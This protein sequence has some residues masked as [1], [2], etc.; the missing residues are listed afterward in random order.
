MSDARR[1]GSSSARATAASAT[2]V[3][4]RTSGQ[5]AHLLRALLALCFL[6][7]AA[8]AQAQTYQWRDVVQEVE[9]RP[10]GDVFV[11]DTRTLW[12]NEDF[13]EAFLCLDLRPPAL[14]PDLRI[15]VTYLDTSGALGSGPTWR[16][17]RQ[18]CDLAGGGRG[19]ELVVRNDRRSPNAG[20]AST[21]Y[22][23]AASK[24][25]RTSSS[26]TGT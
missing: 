22:F 12:T 2:I 9:I 21:T 23:T 4:M 10:N 3:A 24:P 25:T 1:L 16:I 15:T 11:S 13:G 19:V 14:S 17:F 5:R 8:A 7:L 6:L 18:S 20:S 26:G